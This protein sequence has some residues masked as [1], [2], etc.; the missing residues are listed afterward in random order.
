MAGARWT[1]VALLFVGF[2]FSCTGHVTEREAATTG[3][4]EPKADG[5][6]PGTAPG[7]DPVVDPGP[8]TST[9]PVTYCT[10]DY[11]DNSDAV[12][13]PN[14]V[15]RIDLEMSESDWKFQLDNPDLEE[16]RLVDITFCGDVVASAGM[17][18]KRS[19]WRGG[20]GAVSTLDP[21]YVKNNMV[22]DMNEFVQGQRY[23][24]LRKLNLEYVN[25]G[26]IVAQRI[27]FEMLAAHGVRIS[28]VNYADVYMNGDY[29]GVFLNIERVDRSYVNYHYGENDGQLYKHAYCGTFEW[30]G[31]A[32]TAYYDG[33]QYDG[34]PT[35][36]RCYS[37]KPSDSETDFADL[38]HTIDV[39]NNSGADLETALP[40]VW[41]VD[42]WIEMMAG[43]QVIPYGDSPNANGNNFYTYY[44][45][46]G[47]ARVALWDL[48]AGYWN[49]GAPCE[50][51]ADITGWDLTRIG[52]CH[53]GGLPLF[54]NVMAVDNWRHQYFEEAR[55]FLDGS[56]D[57][58]RFAIRVDALAA[59]LADSLA[60]DSNRRSG[61]LGDE[62][63]GDLDEDFAVGL[64]RLKRKQRARAEAVEAQL[65][66]LG[67]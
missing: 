34:N 46:T 14:E 53:R 45:P 7:S 27:N 41:N 62:E 2:S 30:K 18:F 50:R 9:E 4:V 56:F 3:G 58:E 54:D 16:Y 21:G 57:S 20:S 37:P 52:N 22:L 49:D 33:P 63:T 12:Y 35:D 66:N 5:H 61:T 13:E 42:E 51:D 19:T 47:P 6:L 29:L 17:R 31:S 38:I 28:R 65:T 10:R 26:L 60:R 1:R 67:Y 23:R 59:Q 64:A 48:D 40:A 15:I 8:G 11:P 25:D 24:G 43:L 39:L 32:A 55:R 36:P 44:P